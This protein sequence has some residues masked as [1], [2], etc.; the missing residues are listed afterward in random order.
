[1]RIGVNKVQYWGRL[2]SNASVSSA[3]CHS[4]NCFYLSGSC[5]FYLKD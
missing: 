5:S 3:Y 2:S 4:I 1:V